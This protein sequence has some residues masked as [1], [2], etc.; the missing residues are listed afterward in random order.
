MID[1]GVGAYPVLFDWD[2]D[3]LLDLFI[4]NYGEI[5]SV[6]TL[7]GYVN[8]RLTSSISLY[9]NVGTTQQPSFQFIT[10]D[11]AHLSQLKLKAFYPAFADL[12]GDGVINDKD[13]YIYKNP[14][15]DVVF[16]FASSM[17]YRNIDFSFNLRASIG[18]LISEVM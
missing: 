10:K 1:V 15:P 2:A 17:N 11:Y 16:G 4:A 9:K 13:R 7:N 18:K 8:T 6:W 5:D 3:G 12:N 14:D